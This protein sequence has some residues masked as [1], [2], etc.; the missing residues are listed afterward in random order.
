[1]D[2]QCVISG[3]GEGSTVCDVICCIVRREIQWK[4]LYSFTAGECTVS[5]PSLPSPHALHSCCRSSPPSHGFVVLNR[6][7]SDNLLQL[8]PAN[9]PVHVQVP[10]VLFK[11]DGE[12]QATPLSST[13]LT[14]TPCHCR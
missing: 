9:L 2:D 14:T 13:R 6:L 8:I 4:E 5:S 1:M 10:F 11:R 7:S 3:G 12:Y